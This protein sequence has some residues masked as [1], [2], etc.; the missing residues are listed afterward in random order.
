MCR[1]VL[2]VVRRDVLVSAFWLP[3][4]NSYLFHT[5]QIRAAY[6]H[7]TLYGRNHIP[8]NGCYFLHAI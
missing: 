8:S 1:L 4:K 2:L 5:L 3:L 6:I 7:F